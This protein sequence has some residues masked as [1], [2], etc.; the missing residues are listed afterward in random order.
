MRGCWSAGFRGG[1]M[2]RSDGG[3]GGFPPEVLAR[4]TAF[5]LGKAGQLSREAFDRAISPM[6][7]KSRHYGAMAVL[8]AEGPHVQRELGEKMQI[9]RSTMVAVVDELEGMGFVERR[10]DREDRRR[11]ELTLTDAGRVALSQA[12]GLVEGVQ[13]VVLAPLDERQRRELHGLLVSL[14]QAM[15]PDTRG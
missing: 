2:S 5:L 12:D 15:T 9:D 8:A 13:E 11:Y 10:R 14:I 1:T 6:G 7:L 4:H 3:G